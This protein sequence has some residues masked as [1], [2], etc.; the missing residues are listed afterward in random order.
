MDVRINFVT[1]AEIKHALA[2]LNSYNFV[3]YG[4]KHIV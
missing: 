3:V 4:Q 1:K 2:I